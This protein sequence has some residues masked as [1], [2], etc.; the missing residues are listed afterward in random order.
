M[1][2]DF[3]FGKQGLR[4]NLPS[5]FDYRILEPRSAT[6]VSRSRRQPSNR[7]WTIR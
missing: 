2:I 3:A 5:G 7:P 1:Q 6:A 4:L